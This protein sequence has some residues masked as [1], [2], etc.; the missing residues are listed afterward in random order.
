MP[1]TNRWGHAVTRG[2]VGNH[3]ALVYRD[4]PRSMGDVL[5]ESRRWADRPF[6]FQGDRAVTFA[7]T[8]N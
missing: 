7:S 6:I 1:A 3:P 5:V 4:R 8:S 2:S